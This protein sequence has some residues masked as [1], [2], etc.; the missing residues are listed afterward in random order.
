MMKQDPVWRLLY[1]QEQRNNMGS[2]ITIIIQ[3]GFGMA[4]QQGTSGQDGEDG[5]IPIFTRVE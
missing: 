4:P 3:G 1:E 2:G 5:L